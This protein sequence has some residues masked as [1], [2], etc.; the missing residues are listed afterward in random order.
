[1]RFRLTHFEETISCPL[2][3]SEQTSGHE[4]MDVHMNMSWFRTG[5]FL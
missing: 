2:L 3:E 5:Y 1:M 4:S